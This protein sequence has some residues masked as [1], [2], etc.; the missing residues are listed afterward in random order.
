M[1]QEI[2][3]LYNIG[4]EYDLYYA[5]G[6]DS[7]YNKRFGKDK[8]ILR[9]KQII[10]K[11]FHETI[12]K[13]KFKE[14]L[15]PK[16]IKILDYGCGD[17]R[18]FALLESLATFYSKFNINFEICAYDLS[19][20]GLSNYINHLKLRHYEFKINNKI[21]DNNSNG[22]LLASMIKNN[23]KINFIHANPTDSIEEINKLIGEGFHINLCMF[24]VLSHIDTKEKRNH[25]L[26]I[27][28]KLAC[29]EAVSVI[30]VPGKKMFSQ[31]YQVYE[32]LRILKQKIDKY[33]VNNDI[34]MHL[35]NFLES[36]KSD[37]DL[38]YY[39][40]DNEKFLINFCHVFNSKEFI[41][42]LQEANLVVSKI[43]VLAITYIPVLTKKSYLLN[44]A[45]FI[46]SKFFSMK[47]IS[48]NIL[49][50]VADQMVCVAYPSKD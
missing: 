27:F 41:Q 42:E 9:E 11:C 7:I 28:N 26:Q 12:K 39:R 34:S 36:L 44:L 43:E 3:A 23:V 13:L 48:S 8:T 16:T 1:S 32:Y 14:N 4:K 37:G 47:F 45:D 24:S 50:K 21:L 20:V 15:K 2:N 35:R 31:E 19:I 30:T 46:L 5:G 10:K 22:Y 6:E 17:G 25:I 33:N 38:L 40:N 18:I 29:K 49:D